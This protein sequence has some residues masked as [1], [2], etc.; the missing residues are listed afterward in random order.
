MGI[1]TKQN[2]PIF[3]TYEQMCMDKL[4]EIGKSTLMKWAQAMGYTNQN[5]MSKIVKRLR[6]DLIIT[7]SKSKRLHYYEV[8]PKN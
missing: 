8:T 2:K 3:K 7:R 1:G 6:D 4:E 5:S